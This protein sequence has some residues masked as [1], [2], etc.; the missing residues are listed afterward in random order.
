MAHLWSMVAG[1]RGLTRTLRALDHVKEEF[2]TEKEHA[3]TQRK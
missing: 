1:P 2:A 3:L